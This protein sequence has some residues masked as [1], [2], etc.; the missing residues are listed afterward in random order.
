MEK[1]RD[2]LSF[3]DGKAESQ[4]NEMSNARRA[5]YVLNQY[6][7]LTGNDNEMAKKFAVTDAELAVMKSDYE[8]LKHWAD[9]EQSI[10]AVL[11][12][13][14]VAEAKAVKLFENTKDPRD[15]S[16]DPEPP[17]NLQDQLALLWPFDQ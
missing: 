11:D 9:Y 13:D 6:E 12:H 16:G 2:M 5:A 14:L 8:S 17:E 15:R 7:V 1:K 10:N 4:W 3:D